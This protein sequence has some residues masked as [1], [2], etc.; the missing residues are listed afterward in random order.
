[1]VDSL[2]F[3]AFNLSQLKALRSLQI[4]DWAG[5]SRQA[6]A[7]HT[8]VLEVFSTIT[9]PVFSELV[10]IIGVKKVADLSSEDTLFE[11]LRTMNEVK[12][13]KLAFLL[14]APDSR[15]EKARGKLAGA[16]DSVVARGLLD[17]L[18]SPPAIRCARFPEHAWCV[19]FN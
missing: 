4:R 2:P 13:F 18:D 1:V 7:R 16:L 15:R 9:S 3:P 8:I 5:N 10:I 6:D 17:F 11:T 12:P 19:P 14:M